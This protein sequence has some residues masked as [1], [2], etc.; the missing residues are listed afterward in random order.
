MNMAA[1]EFVEKFSG[2]NRSP[3]GT[4]TA[5]RLLREGSSPTAAELQSEC[6][7]CEGGLRIDKYPREP[8]AKVAKGWTGFT[9]AYSRIG[10]ISSL[11]RC[12]EDEQ[13]PGFTC[14]PSTARSHS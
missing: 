5:A 12:S 10:S 3:Y 2:R 14:R 4:S 9:R 1:D 6:S 11:F 13:K 8:S 7:R